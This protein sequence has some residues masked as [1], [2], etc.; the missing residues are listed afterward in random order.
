MGSE[1]GSNGMTLSLACP[2][3]LYRAMP[4]TALGLGRL[5]APETHLR[6]HR[7]P[8]N[9]KPGKGGR[10]FPSQASGLSRRLEEGW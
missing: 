2:T 7:I 6:W 4:C 3:V 10:K 9:I 5:Q 8:H 1:K